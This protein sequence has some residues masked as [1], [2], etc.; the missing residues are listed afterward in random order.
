MSV[1][2]IKNIATPILKRNKVKKAALFGS[3]A[4]Q[5]HS[6]NSDIDILVE[7]DDTH[8]L[9]DFVGIKLDLEDALHKK[10]DLVEF[11]SVR[12]ELQKYIL[13]SPILIYG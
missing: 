1:E 5:D 2:E 9:L 7:L 6:V 10:V 12:P 11:K 13:A 4:R 3:Y 8:S